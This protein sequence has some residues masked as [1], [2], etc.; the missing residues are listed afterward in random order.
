MAKEVI[1]KTREQTPAGTVVANIGASN[2]DITA[3][4]VVC[5]IS[6]DET[7]WKLLVDD[8]GTLYTEEVT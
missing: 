3:D 6:P 1:I 5:L 4:G 7:R 2:M 8:E